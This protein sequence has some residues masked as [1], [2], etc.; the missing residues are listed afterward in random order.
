MLYN[1]GLW[2]LVAKGVQCGHLCS[3]WIFG[4]Y[5]SDTAVGTVLVDQCSA[6]SSP[7]PNQL[8]QFFSNGKVFLGWGNSTAPS[9]LVQGTKQWHGDLRCKV[10]GAPLTQRA[11]ATL[12]KHS[13]D[14]ARDAR[15]FDNFVLFLTC[16]LLTVK[17]HC[18]PDKT[19]QFTGC[20]FAIFEW[21]AVALGCMF[22]L[23]ETPYFLSSLFLSGL[24]ESSTRLKP[25]E[26]Q[27]YRKKALWV[28]WLSII[29][30][31]ALAVAA[32]SEYQGVLPINILP[33]LA[34]PSNPCGSVLCF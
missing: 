23:M 19:S 18:G 10:C 26:A 13:S 28:S 11:S 31:L 27:N 33:L 9:D 16:N 3:L 21:D 30:T 25:H 20:G 5:E 24:L 4:L 15:I 14:T 34:F 2:L 1:L 29:V 32:F 12:G 8:L 7:M 17:A 22:C 6:L